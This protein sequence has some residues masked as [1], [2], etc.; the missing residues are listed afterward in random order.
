M[1]VF[2][3]K[4]HKVLLASVA[5]PTAL[6]MRILRPFVLVRLRALDIG[7]IGGFCVAD[8]YISDMRIG[9]G[10]NKDFDIFYSVSLNGIC[11]RQWLKMWKRVLRIFPMGEFGRIVEKVNKVLP[12]YETHKIRIHFNQ[13]YDGPIGFNTERYI[14]A[15]AQSSITFTQEEEIIGKQALRKIGIP[16]EKPFVCFHARDAAYLDKVH[17]D[18]DWRYHNHR[19]SNIH[20]YIPAVERLVCDGYYAIRMGAVVREKLS[21]ADPKIIDYATNGNRTDFL[22]IY[23]GA[24][25]AFFICDTAGIYIVPAVFRRPIA[26]VNY[27]SMKWVHLF[28]NKDLFI[29]KKLWLRKERRFLTFKEILDSPVGKFYEDRQFEEAGIE[30][31][32]NTPE[33]ILALV[34]EMEGRLKQEWRA[35]EE[36]EELQKRFWALFDKDFPARV[37]LSRVGT[38]FLRQNR[39]LLK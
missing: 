17:P 28:C 37:F 5:L 21:V 16:E 4:L 35:N 30:I 38:E 26:W 27:I 39:Q 19:D 6:L 12:G 24:R 32:E 11:N 15:R 3:Q 25:C 18:I 7:R 1:P 22:D 9:L 29:F 34:L 10:N 13:F 14:S 33:E 23:L 31:I 8:W 36:D 2:F 20:N